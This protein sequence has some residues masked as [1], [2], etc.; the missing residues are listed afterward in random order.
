MN[1]M[2]EMT[3]A[4]KPAPPVWVFILKFPVIKFIQ[5][6]YRKFCNIDE[7]ENKSPIMTVPRI[8]TFSIFLYF[9]YFQMQMCICMHTYF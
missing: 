4:L 9:L 8:T 1:G 2:L 7:E 6:Y 5:V 3:L